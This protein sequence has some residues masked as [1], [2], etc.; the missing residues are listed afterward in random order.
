MTS[1]D[2][3]CFEGVVAIGEKKCSEGRQMFECKN[4][5]RAW[6]PKRKNVQ[7]TECVVAVGE[8]KCSKSAA[9]VGE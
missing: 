4:V 9:A 2:N 6:L 7:K 1:E 3:K 5:Q 8:K